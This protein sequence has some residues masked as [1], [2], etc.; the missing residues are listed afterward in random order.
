MAAPTGPYL[1]SQSGLRGSKYWPAMSDWEL[2]SRS[3]TLG[4][5]WRP[6]ASEEAER[7]AAASGPL[8]V[9]C[10]LRQGKAARANHLQGA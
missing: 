1:Q 7:T 8:G 5:A 6:A 4:F 10:P 2:E 9:A 3:F